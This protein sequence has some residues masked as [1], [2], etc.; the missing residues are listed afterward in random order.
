M[1]TALSAWD[2]CSRAQG[3]DEP[4]GGVGGKD[5]RASGVWRDMH[6][7]FVLPPAALAALALAACGSSNSD[8]ATVG[9]QPTPTTSSS[10][11]ASGSKVADDASGASGGG[12]VEMYDNYFKPKTITGKPG[13]MVKIELKNEGKAEHNF[14]IDGQKADA[15]VEPGEDATVSVKIPKSGSVQFYCE[16]HKGLGMVGTVKA[17]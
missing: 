10:S 3:R 1:S 6:R 4:P 9:S 16:Y 2:V 7:L 15:D 14:K 17:S 12:E 13:Q 5:R 11:G 8:T